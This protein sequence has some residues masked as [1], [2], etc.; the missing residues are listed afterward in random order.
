MQY[1]FEHK[2]LLN[3]QIAETLYRRAAT[4]MKPDPHGDEKG[5][6]TV[7]NIY[8]D[9]RHDSF[10]HAK[11]LGHH[12]RDKYRVRYYNS[13]ISYIRL[14][15]KHKK[16]ILIHKE[17]LP[18]T[19]WQMGQIKAG[20][21]DFTLLLDD[22]LWKKVA[23]IHRLHGLC[24]TVAFAYRRETLIYTPGNVRLTFDGP[25][26]DAGERVP[27]R[28]TTLAQ[29]YGRRAYELLLEIKYTGFLPEIVRSL[30]NGLPLVHTE[31]SKYGVARERGYMSVSHNS[32]WR[33]G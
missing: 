26:F 22:P 12:S 11:L 21:L 3:P 17:T 28:P 2:Y 6:Y 18:I 32:G 20:D 23:T 15:R 16:G 5:G 10:Y 14:E 24:P 19:P 30:L 1:R 7:N 27:L 33:I 4:I 29:S 9:D 25:L 31:M 13:D 8:L